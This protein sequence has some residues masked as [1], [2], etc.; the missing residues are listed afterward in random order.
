MTAVREIEQIVDNAP[1]LNMSNY[2][3]EEVDELNSAMIEIC[4]ILG[5][6]AECES[7][8]ATNEDK[9]ALPIYIVS[10]NEVAVCAFH[11]KCKL[12]ESGDCVPKC[13]KDYKAQ[14]DC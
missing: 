4:N 3:E 10:N 9:A 5:N 7:Q 12:Y 11:E 13:C 14:T 2:N 6:L 8:E 1:E